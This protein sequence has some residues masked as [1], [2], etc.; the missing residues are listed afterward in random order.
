MDILGFRLTPNEG[1]LQL[2]DDAKQILDIKLIEQAHLVGASSPYP[3]LYKRVKADSFRYFLT[4]SDSILIISDDLDCLIRQT[5]HF[6]SNAFGFRGWAFKTGYNKPDK[7]KNP[8]K[9]EMPHFI[10]SKDKFEKEIITE[11]WYPL[12][13][14]GGLTHG[15][16][17]VFDTTNIYD[18]KKVIVKNA[19]GKALVDAV[20][21][22]SLEWPKGP[23]IFCSEYIANNAHRLKK[24]IV[25]TDTTC[26]YEIL[27]PALSIIEENMA[28]NPEGEFFDI[29]DSFLEPAIHLWHYFSSE[30]YSYHYKGF[31]ELVLKSM[32]IFNPKDELRKSVNERLAAFDC[33]SRI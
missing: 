20:E 33:G 26:I 27:W 7:S 4:G 8:L 16:I 28:V 21:L 11:K 2:L 32:L 25:P 6:L 9:Q 10:I 22:E 13:Y 3:D 29:I 5:A 31:V 19:A 24:Y 15:E 12:F 30:R 18:K 14:R 1:K 17:D 23:R